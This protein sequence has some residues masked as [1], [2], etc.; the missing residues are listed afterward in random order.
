MRLGR[1]SVILGTAASAVMRAPSVHAES[2]FASVPWVAKV[3]SKDLLKGRLIVGFQGQDP[4]DDGVQSV[5]RDIEDGVIGGVILLQRN[6][7]SVSQLSNLISFLRSA[8]GDVRPIIAI[9]HEG[10]RVA[11]AAPVAGFQDW[12]AAREVGD[13]YPSETEAFDY[14]R[15][16]TGELAF[17]GINL[18]LAPVVDLDFGADGAV[19]GRLGR[20][21]S[22]EPGIVADIARGLIRAHHDAGVQ[23]CLKHFPGHG[24]AQADTHSRQVDV[25]EV[26][27]KIELS[28]F[29]TLI[30]EGLADM[31]M[32]SHLQLDLLAPKTPSPLSLSREANRYLRDQMGYGGPVITDDMQMGAVTSVMEEG[33]AA[34]GAVLAGNDLLIYST[35]EVADLEIGRRVFQELT[36]HSDSFDQAELEGSAD[37]MAEFRRKL[38][39]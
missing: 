4:I 33:D 39:A 35:F 24:S 31:I 2:S 5:A 13:T 21:F 25:G 1:R 27:S 17:A 6:I 32:M 37:R 15:P 28:P 10:G 30:S 26:W 19:I 22:S 36:H 14:Y 38:T 11:R 7:S 12:D 16:R 8:G 20:A 23:T 18:N 29:Q 9:D 34:T 3:T